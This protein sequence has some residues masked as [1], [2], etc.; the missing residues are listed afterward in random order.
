ME[1]RAQGDG[2]GRWGT[3]NDKCALLRS[4][5]F[6]MIHTCI[7]IP[8]DRNGK[9]S[10]GLRQEVSIQICSLK[11][12]YSRLESTQNRKTTENGHLLGGIEA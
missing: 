12:L 8:Q 1:Q 10:A 4:T 3:G 2:E 9:Q 11:D 7:I 6:I 5:D